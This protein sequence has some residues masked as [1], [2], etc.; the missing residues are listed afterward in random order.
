MIINPVLLSIA[1]AH[2]IDE[3]ID[4]GQVVTCAEIYRDILLTDFAP[5]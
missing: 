3:H 1:S 5:G 4:I 2:A